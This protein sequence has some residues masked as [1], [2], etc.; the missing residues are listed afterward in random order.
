VVDST[1]Q[2]ASLPIVMTVSVPHEATPPRDPRN[3]SKLRQ[4][5]EFVR[6]SQHPADAWLVG[7]CVRN[8]LLHRNTNDLDLVVPK[9]AI[10]LARAVADAFGGGF[11]VLDQ[12]RDVARAIVRDTEERTLEVDVARLRGTELLVD[13]SL[14]DFTINAMAV[15]I[16]D[17]ASLLDSA[18]AGR[19]SFAEIIDPFGGRSDLT[20]G[21]IRAV[22]EGAFLDDPLRMLRAVRQAAELGFRI[23]GATYNLIRRDSPLLTAAASER[24]RDELVRMLALPY[25]GGW[26]HLRVL[27]DAGLLVQV[28]PEVAAMAGVA[29]SPP[30]YQDVF[31]HTRSVLAHLEG[32]YSLIWPASDWRIP[33]PMPEESLP[34]L[35]DAAWSDLAEVIEPYRTELR[36]HL[37]APVSEGR[38]RRD[39]L[40]W[41]ALAH[42]WGKPDTRLVEG[43]LSGLSSGQ[44][45]FLG[46]D[47]RGATLVE[48]RLRALHMSADEVGHIA[49]LVRL[50]MRPGYLSHEHPPSRRAVYRFF[51][52][53]AGTGPDC[54]V[55]SLAD[56]AAIRAGNPVLEQWARRLATA[57]LLFDTYFRHRSE[58]VHPPPLL[59]GRQLMSRFGLAPG[60]L[61]G[62]LLE[63]LREAQAAGEVTNLEEALGWLA[64]QVHRGGS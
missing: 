14:R 20:Q 21:V 49:R 30:H 36:T 37:L 6:R 58:R 32:L 63:G 47:D 56:F 1:H 43:A 17:T 46:H 54:V 53:A 15:P 11:F 13:L 10:P 19:S 31:D 61:V 8:W 62:I 5:L 4:V 16:A 51:R 29:Q 55:L 42:D 33:Q 23:E 25:G 52:E 3:V 18:P 40:A 59:D 57:G 39:W 44:T 45:R 38:S 64:Q 41:A 22:T 2:S 60:P 28:L 34:I 50:H 12:E 26:H 24:V 27:Q 9:G 7:G 35:D 48:A